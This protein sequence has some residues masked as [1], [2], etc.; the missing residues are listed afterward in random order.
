M[1]PFS[2]NVSILVNADPLPGQLVVYDISGR[3]MRILYGNGGNSF[4]WEGCDS[5]G[6]ELPGGNYIIRGAS[7]GNNACASVAKL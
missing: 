2:E 7:A 4:L 6:N 3:M 5:E 1:N